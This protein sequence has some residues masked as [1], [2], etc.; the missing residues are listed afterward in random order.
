[1]TTDFELRSS[2]GWGIDDFLKSAI[3][4]GLWVM[5]EAG[6]SRMTHATVLPN[7]TVFRQAAARLLEVAAAVDV[8][9]FKR[10]QEPPK[11]PPFQRDPALA[12]AYARADLI[13]AKWE[14]VQKRKDAAIHAAIAK[15]KY[16]KAHPNFRNHI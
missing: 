1:M 12:E 7:P 3:R 13:N 10:A 15:K 8:E 14:E 4:Y 16:Q 6:D 5:N 2:E 11:P 9:A